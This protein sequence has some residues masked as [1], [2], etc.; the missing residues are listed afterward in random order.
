M[1]ARSSLFP[2]VL[3]LA[4]CVNVPIRVKGAPETQLEWKQVVDKKEPAY[5]VATDGTTCT[6][7]AERFKKTEL[8]KRVLCAWQ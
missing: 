6:V 3:L 1:R 7:D 4:A 5:R 2:L 8:G